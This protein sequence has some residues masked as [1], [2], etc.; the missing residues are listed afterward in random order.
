MVS[1]TGGQIVCEY[2]R[3][4]KVPYIVGIPGH[5]ILPFLDAFVDQNDVKPIMV[6][7]EQAAAHVADGYYRASGRPL[8]VF[9]SVGPGACNT[10]TGVATAYVDSSAMVV[11]TGSVQTYMFGRGILQEIERKHWSDFWQVIEPV[12]KRSWQVTRVDQLPRVLTQAFKL[13]TTGRPGPVHID[14]PVDIQAEA[15]DVEIPEPAEHRAEGRLRGDAAQINK[16]VKLLLSAKRP[17]I[18][19]GGGTIISNASEELSELA[20]FLGAPVMTTFRGI[21]KGVF[22]EDHPLY[23]FY[24]GHATTIGNEITTKSDVILVVG[25]RL[26]DETTGSFTPGET[27]N[28]PPTK[29]IHVDIDSNEIGKNIATEIGIIGDAKSVLRDILEV[30]HSSRTQKSRKSSYTQSEYFKEIQRLRKDWEGEVEEQVNS[31]PMSI[32]RVLKEARSFLARDSIVISSAGLPQEIVH[33]QFPIYYPRTY[34]SSGGY[35]TMG[36][37][38]PAAIGAQLAAPDKQVLAVEGDG[39][40]L[41]TGEEMTTAVQYGL[42][43][44]V[45]L[46]NN[47]GWVSIRDHQIRQHGMERTIATEFIDKKGKLYSPDF[48][49]LAEAYRCY[50]EKVERP[51]DVKP[52]LRRAFDSGKPAIVEAIVARKFPVS[53]AKGY[54]VWDLAPIPSYLRS[55]KGKS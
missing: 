30:M 29:V 47:Y 23:G 15:A 36:F 1:L 13:A 32:A 44:V 53:G 26:R 8:G 49:K 4:E 33:Q 5:G 52:A 16:A 12:V 20:E 39:S 46:L 18:I 31:N 43:I 38:I 19:A 14:L 22:P 3:K 35:S 6:K 34:I 51:E 54:R 50:G 40:F 25:S 2:L 17:S 45:L 55:R 24:P 27:F 7:H 28:V 41:M 42:P 9:T 37:G 21:S 48:V 11:F 10:V